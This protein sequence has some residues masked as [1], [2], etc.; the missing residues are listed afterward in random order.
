[1]I[2]NLVAM[3][4]CLLCCVLLVVCSDVMCVALFVVCVAISLFA[5]LGERDGEKERGRQRRRE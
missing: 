4:G 1:M 3:K 5:R 2:S